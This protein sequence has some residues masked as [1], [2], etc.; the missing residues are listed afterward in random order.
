MQRKCVAVVGLLVCLAVLATPAL[1][2]FGHP[3]KG[4]WSGW[5]R[6]NATTEHRIL[7]EFHWE[8]KYNS[9][10][11]GGTLSGTLNPGSD[12]APM[13]N[14]R[15][16]PPSGGVANADAPWE[17]H[18]ET[19]I[20]DAAGMPVKVVVDGFM[21]NLGAYKRVIHGTWQEGSRK[22]PFRVTANYGL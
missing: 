3:L 8:G 2:Q 15:L 6:E 4:S 22:G 1:G 11:E 13:T 17:L 7:L 19:T 20:K 16:T 18:F 10:R 12:S 14:L 21:E 5:W 9:N